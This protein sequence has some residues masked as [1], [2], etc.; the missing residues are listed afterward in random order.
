[1]ERVVRNALPSGE[2]LGTSRP[3]PASVLRCESTRSDTKAVRRP[4]PGFG[5]DRGG[6]VLSGHGFSE[7]RTRIL[8]T[9]GESAT[10]T[11]LEGQAPSR[12]IRRPP[13][14]GIISKMQDPWNRWHAS[15]WTRASPLSQKVGALPS[16]RFRGPGLSGG[17]V[18]RSRWIG[19]LC[20][21]EKYPRFRPPE[22]AASPARVSAAMILTVRLPEIFAAMLTV[23]CDTHLRTR[24]PICS[25]SRVPPPGDAIK[26][27]HVCLS[28]ELCEPPCPT[29]PDQ[30]RLTAVFPLPA[31]LRHRK[32]GRPPEQPEPEQPD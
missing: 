29:A 14:S 25:Y 32:T 31:A 8:R 11:P 2:I 27:D 3:C 15:P 18:S 1:M 23:S 5:S 4:T 16:S 28:H 19:R 17:V 24:I 13:K 12:P 9:A 26:P 10:Q 6:A 30:Q 20:F 7:V 21:R 22:I